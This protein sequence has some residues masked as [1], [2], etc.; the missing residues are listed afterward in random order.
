MVARE[1]NI[2]PIEWQLAD[3]VARVLASTGATLGA[4]QGNKSER[5]EQ[6]GNLHAQASLD[7][8]KKDGASATSPLKDSRTLCPER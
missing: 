1:V 2:T 6:S 4:A 7:K 8:L 3:G 5:H